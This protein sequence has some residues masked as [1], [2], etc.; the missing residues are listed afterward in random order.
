MGPLSSDIYT[1]QKLILNNVDAKV[2]LT[3]N[4]PTFYAVS[5]KDTPKY[6][7]R[8]KSA[9][10]FVKNVFVNPQ[11]LMETEKTL[12][13]K[14][15]IYP[16]KRNIVRNFTIPGDSKSMILDN[17]SMGVLPQTIIVCLITNSA[18]N[19]ESGVNPLYF[20]NFHMSSTR[21]LL[22]VLS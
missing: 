22:M 5:S 17:V 12:L 9:H 16:I 15:A 14:P 10:L 3:L 2:T 13:Q 1:Q 19:G 11:L 21:C 6:L 8:I 20:R 18:F 7:L 4:K